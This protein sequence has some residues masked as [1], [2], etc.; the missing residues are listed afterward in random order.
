MTMDAGQPSYVL[1]HWVRDTGLLSVERAVHKLTLE[2]AQLFGL[3]DRGVLRPG[4]H[5]DVNVIDLDALRL[6]T[7]ELV[8]DLPLGAP[9]YTQRARGYDYTLV[10]GC[11][12]IEADQLTDARPGQVVRSTEL[13]PETGART[14]ERR[15]RDDRSD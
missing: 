8:A 13:G 5:A 9:R 10:N 3:A 7:P 14:S 1:K 15:H 12:V 6:D 2:G 11:V 4:A